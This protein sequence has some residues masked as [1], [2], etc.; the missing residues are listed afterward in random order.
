MLILAVGITFLA[1]AAAVFLT[2][3]FVTFSLTTKAIITAAITLSTMG[4]AERADGENS[5][6]R[7]KVWPSL[8]AS[9]SPWM[10]GPFKHSTSSA[11]PPPPIACTGEAP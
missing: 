4:I 8:G 2:V 1:I 7:L 3:A 11:L 9:F 5:R 6:L 10:P